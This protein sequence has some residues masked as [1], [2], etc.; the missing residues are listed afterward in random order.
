[1][2]VVER[3]HVLADD[4]VVNLLKRKRLLAGRREEN[5]KLLDVAA[6][7]R[8][9]GLRGVALVAQ[10]PHEF[11]DGFLHGPQSLATVE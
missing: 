3:A 10:I 5:A 1:M 9:R 2:P 8:E 7:F 6:I 11:F 4:A